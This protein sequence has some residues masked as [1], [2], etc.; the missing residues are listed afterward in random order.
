M[1]GN[2]CSVI[3]TVLSHREARRIDEFCDAW[4]ER[5]LKKADFQ[6]VFFNVTVY[7]VKATSSDNALQDNALRR[8]KTRLRKYSF[9]EVVS[10]KIYAK[11][12]QYYKVCYLVMAER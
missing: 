3:S 9:L 11:Q 12:C 8:M 7:I 2:G 10:E 4:T 5:S 1:K 6:P